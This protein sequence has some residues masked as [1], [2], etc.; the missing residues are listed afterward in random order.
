MRDYP[1][2]LRIKSDRI[3][4]RGDKRYADKG[5]LNSFLK[6]KKN[7]IIEEKI[8]GSQ[9]AVGWKG[10]EPYSQGKNSHIPESDKRPQ[11]NG[12]RR[13]VWENY[14]ML[15]Q[16]KGY[17]IYGEWAKIQHHVPY[18]VL[19]NWF[20][21][22]DIFSLKQKRFIDYNLK[23]E[24]LSNWGF[25]ITPLLHRGKVDLNMIHRLTIDQFSTFSENNHMEGCVIKDYSAQ[26]FIK[27]VTREFSDGIEDEG[28]W[29]SAH[30]QRLNHLESL[31]EW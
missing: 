2:L 22:F 7:L 31:A 18:E 13:W 27:F 3:Q 8:D 21:A 17:L 1:E 9:I 19:P 20:I 14:G 26:K 24:M 15:E 29:T 10:D 4:L 12:V 28:H 23:C 16:T 6:G 25:E 11:Y 5:Q 30:R